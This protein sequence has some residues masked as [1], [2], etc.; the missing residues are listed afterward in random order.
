LH[1][2]FDDRNLAAVLNSLQLSVACAISVAVK[3]VL[4]LDELIRLNHFL[5]LCV[6][7]KVKV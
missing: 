3:T 1:V 5:E 7:H 2:H 4:M 6:I